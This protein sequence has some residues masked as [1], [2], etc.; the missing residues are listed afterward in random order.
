L[1]GYTFLIYQKLGKVPLNSLKTKAAR[2]AFLQPLIERMGAWAIDSDLIEQ[3]KRHIVLLNKLF[4]FVIGT[5]FLI[6]KL[7]TRETQDRKP[8]RAMFCHQLLQL[9]IIFFR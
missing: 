3:R 2:Y 9:G 8:R 7:V 6:T 4:D 5:G 1:N